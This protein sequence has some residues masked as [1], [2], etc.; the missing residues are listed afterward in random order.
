[1]GVYDTF[2]DGKY[3]VQL[4]TFECS[5]STYEKGDKLPMK[6]FGY[7]KDG[8][9]FC[10][11]NPNEG[12]VIVKDSVFIGIMK[13]RDFMSSKGNRMALFEHYPFRVWDCWGREYDR[14]KMCVKRETMKNMSGRCL[15]WVDGWCNS[16]YANGMKCNAKD[17]KNV[18]KRCPYP[19]RVKK[20]VKS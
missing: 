1:M 16:D 9:F 4:K 17:C 8:L 2:K 18:P 20:E 15:F 5:L 3:E 10:C 13:V 14:E 12:V 6:R 19:C 11:C 7:P